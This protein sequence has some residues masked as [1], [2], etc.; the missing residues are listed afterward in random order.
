MKGMTRLADVD[1][2]DR[3]DALCAEALD[4]EN[5][6]HLPA[7]TLVAVASGKNVTDADAL[8]AAPGRR[9]GGGDGVMLGKPCL[10]DLSRRIGALEI[11][12]PTTGRRR[13]I[14]GGIFELPYPTSTDP[15]KRAK[16]LG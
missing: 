11:N 4:R 13:P 2:G 14:W 15:Q 8:F 6:A 16:R 10:A 5:H 9:S 7:G 3:L 12:R 1:G